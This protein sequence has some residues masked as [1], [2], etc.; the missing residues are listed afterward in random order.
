MQG[1]LYTFYSSQLALFPI[2]IASLYAKRTSAAAG[3]LSLA[4]AIPLTFAASIHLVEIGG[5]DY[6]L[7]P[8]LVA[9]VVS[10]VIYVVAVTVPARLICV[11]SR[12]HVPQSPERMIAQHE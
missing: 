12:L 6:A 8:P 10:S 9:V 11:D 7:V 3:I 2:V 4:I 1:V 5:P